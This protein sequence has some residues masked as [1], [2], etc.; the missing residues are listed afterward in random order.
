LNSG[1]AI[2]LLAF[3]GNVRFSFSFSL[4]VKKIPRHLSRCTPA[5]SCP[6]KQAAQ[7]K[8]RFAAAA[9]M[10]NLQGAHNMRAI[11]KKVEKIVDNFKFEVGASYV[12]MKGVYEVVSI[13]KETMTIR[14]DDGRQVVTDIDLQRRIIDRLAYEEDA[15]QKEDAAAKAAKEPKRKRAPAAK[16]TAEVPGN[17]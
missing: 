2:L 16:A 6:E 13:D 4:L 5:K 9:K 17:E 11:K 7:D 14:W 12:N 1:D 8:R 10:E 3:R 15:R